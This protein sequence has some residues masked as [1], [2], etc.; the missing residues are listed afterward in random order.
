MLKEG[1]KAP[2][3][4]LNDQDGKPVSL[5]DYLG[6]QVVLYFYPKDDTPG[7]TIEAIEFTKLKK[8][9]E[10]NNAIVIGISKDSCES[11]KKFKTTYLDRCNQLKV[12]FPFLDLS[13]EVKR[14]N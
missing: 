1:N 12:K 4:K 10:E 13:D 7:C 9:F 8:E 3:F 5:K 14:F 6:K 11:H 2:A